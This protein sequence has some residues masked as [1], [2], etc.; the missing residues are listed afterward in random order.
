MILNTPAQCASYSSGVYRVAGGLLLLR[1]ADGRPFQ[2][3]W[4][5]EGFRVSYRGFVSMSDAS[6]EYKG[7]AASFDATAEWVGSF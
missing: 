1:R 2:I 5:F 4:D 7:V 3:D 6:W